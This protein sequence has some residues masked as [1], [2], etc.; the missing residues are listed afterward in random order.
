M[1]TKRKSQEAA[2]EQAGTTA[3]TASKGIA[4]TT[5][6]AWLRPMVEAII[7]EATAKASPPTP[8]TDFLGLVRHLPMYGSR[9]LRNLVKRKIIPSVRPPGT[10]KLG[11][12]LPSV[13]AALLRFQ[14]GGI[15]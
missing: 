9:T 6:P 10:R 7:D 13:E 5:E 11:F 12:F 1:T 8:F 14:R 3:G 4:S 15:E 2:E